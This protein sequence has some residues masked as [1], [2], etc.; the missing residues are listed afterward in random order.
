M[1]DQYI[2]LLRGINVGGHTVKMDQLR[3]LFTEAGLSNVRSYINS[4][5]LFFDTEETD[6]RLLS[7]R[8]ERHLA[9][10]LGF[11]VPVFLRTAAEL[12]TI[13][14]KDPFKN[15]ERSEDKRFC[16]VFTEEPLN[17]KLDL[18]IHSSRKDMDLIAVNRYEAFIV[19]YIV[20]GRPPSGTFPTDILPIRITSRFFHTLAK[21]F[22]AAQK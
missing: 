11:E 5:N 2:A 6:L 20:D 22:Q 8:I 10:A 1:A 4:G 14:A 15:I 17:E 21:I 7:Q 9:D 13:L 19:W 3:R 18:P 16:V 12:E